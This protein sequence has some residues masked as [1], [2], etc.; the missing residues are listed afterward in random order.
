MEGALNDASGRRDWTAAPSEEWQR[1]HGW[2]S[3]QPPNLRS[4]LG[5]ETWTR[6]PLPKPE[7]LLGDLVTTTTRTFLVGRTG[8]GK[9]LLAFA[10][11][12]GMASGEGFL[13]WRSSRPAKVLVIDGEMP[14][15][16]IRQRA[17]D[18]LRHTTKAPDA[19]QLLIFARDLEDDFAKQFP[20][21]GLMPTLNTKAGR[22]WV[23]ALIDEI[24]GVDVVIF[25]N[26]MSLLDGDQ[27][28]EVP[29]SDTLLLVQS[30]TAK[31]IGQIWLDHTGHNSNHQY[32]S[33]TKAWRFDSVGIMTPL[34]DD[35]TTRGEVAFRLSFEHP[36]KCRRRT[37]DNWQD[38]EACTIRLAGDRWSCDEV[39]PV[40]K[41][42]TGLEAV[43]PLFRK[44]HAALIGAIAAAGAGGSTTVE[45]W[46]AECYRRGLIEQADSQD[47]AKER[48]ARLATFRAAKSALTK[49][50]CIAQ[51][52]DLIRDL[53]N[54]R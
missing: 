31:R 3:G 37:P 21:L 1:E 12:C 17:I 46:K 26:V 2:Q 13:H 6:R 35:Q 51:D 33:S 48:G 16:L 14:G 44:F 10:M 4:F 29:W 23:L 8:L 32:G 11:A 5:I 45:L 49:H 36:G 19:G 54:P 39:S 34:S 9:T 27:K 22:N 52:G 47:G 28:D 42:A 24:G 7:R 18:T 15:E 43:G 40:A 25:D 53:T 38:F 50:G 41:Q 20:S 30:L